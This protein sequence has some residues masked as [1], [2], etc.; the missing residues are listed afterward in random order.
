MPQDTQLFIN[1]KWVDSSD[2]NTRDIVNPATGDTI[3]QVAQATPDDI[4]QV[5]EASKT[6]FDVWKAVSAWDRAKVLKKAAALIGVRKEA[7]ASLMTKEQGKP[8][9]ESL[10]ELERCCD[11]FEWCAEQAT[12]SYGRVYPQR[13]SGA[14]Q[15]TL[16]QPVGPVAAF[17]P[18]NFPAAMASRKLAAALGAGCSIILKPSDEAPS[19]VAQI[20][21]ILHEAGVPAGAVQQITGPA[22]AL[23]EQLI[24]SPIIEK[25]SLTGSIPVGR[26]LS[27]MAGQELKSVTMEL[28]G[29]A[30][31]VVFDDADIEHAVQHTATFKFRNAGQVCLGVSR[32]F[33]QENVYDAFYR[34]F[35]E[36]M[37][38]I[39]VG[40]GMDDGVTMGP[41]ANN[42]RVA[43]MEQMVA[44]AKSYGG[45]ITLGGNRIGKNG[46][47]FEPT[48]IRNLPDNSQLM[49]EEPFGPV[50][51]VSSFK[52]F[53][54]VIERANALRFGLA[55]Y[56]FTSSLK[57]ATDIAD[58]F[59]AG[60]IGINEFTP[61]LAEAPF[62][63]H[64]DSGIG[65]EGGPEGFEA[66]FK[67]KFVSQQIV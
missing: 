46:C 58:Q 4:A 44:N 39:R 63:G 28:G 49:T 60:W 3:G 10:G 40:N 17:S 25:V 27:S 62:G 43:A 31:V 48:L 67:T 12:R 37:K 53:D 50:A 29:H 14:R 19:A 36:Y 32:I 42:R 51:P 57:T 2:R 45:E 23:S 15:I 30:P 56:A 7:I 66:Y 41:L 47:F 11:V 35:A 61:A 22:A 24:K 5:L 6:G 34:R 65:C 8:L 55:A 64:K 59:E 33:V 26:L 13:A 54:E 52:T 21:Q 1:G 9:A 20:I 16:K 38:H 18:W